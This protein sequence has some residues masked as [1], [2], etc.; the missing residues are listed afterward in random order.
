MTLC[1]TRAQNAVGRFEHFRKHKM[2][3]VVTQRGRSMIKNCAERHKEQR[4]ITFCSLK[5]V[6][7]QFVCVC[8]YS[9][10]LCVFY[11][12]GVDLLAMLR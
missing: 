7:C 1:V 5:T 9:C 8:V 10:L 3:C 4:A 12:S 2:T 11:I 6:F